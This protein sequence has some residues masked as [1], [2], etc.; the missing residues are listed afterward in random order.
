MNIAQIR[1]ATSGAP[2]PIIEKPGTPARPTGSEPTHRDL[3]QVLSTELG[4]LLTNA[5]GRLENDLRSVLESA[6]TALTALERTCEAASVKLTDHPSASAA[7]VPEL[8]ERFVDAAA[9]ETKAAVQR[10]RAQGQA[11]IARLEDLVARLKTEVQ[12]ERDQL[13]TAREQLDTQRD[14]CARAEAACEEAKR[15]GARIVTT[16]KA[17]LQTLQADL[18]AERARV[19][20]LTREIDIATDER[21][22]LVAAVQAVRRAV[23]FAEPAGSAEAPQSD[24]VPHDSSPHLEPTHQ[25]DLGS[26]PG[27]SSIV[28]ESRLPAESTTTNQSVA[29]ADDGVAL[30]PPP[31]PAVVANTERFLAEIERTYQLDVESERSPIEV[32]DRLVANLRYARSEVCQSCNSG[33]DAGLLFEQQMMMLVDARSGTA[34]ARHLGIAAHQLALSDD[35]RF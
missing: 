29:D 28:A 19:S 18:E 15:E 14:A 20:R 22:K 9:H 10:A 16:F 34:F 3:R 8:V 24:P 21:S 1:L 26:A 13:R 25:A 7:A 5:E 27:R 4:D 31:D 11:D 35:L 33:M 17:Q 12:A 30:E 2:S 6:R 32:V 23:S